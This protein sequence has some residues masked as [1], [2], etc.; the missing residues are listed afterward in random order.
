[1]NQ[2]NMMGT[3]CIKDAVLFLAANLP[4]KSA[5]KFS[6]WDIVFA[7]ISVVYQTYLPV[8]MIVVIVTGL[9]MMLGRRSQ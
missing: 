2:K 9:I 3:M 4:G 8:I 5:V 7:F 6:D 1:L